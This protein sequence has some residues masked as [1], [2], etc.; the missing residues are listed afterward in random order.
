MD[1][2]HY[3]QLFSSVLVNAE[4]C[5]QD[6]WVPAIHSGELIIRSSLTVSLQVPL[7]TILIQCYISCPA[8]LCWCHFSESLIHI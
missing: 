2:S 7:C 3:F 8:S 1:F 4:H 6:I 5:E